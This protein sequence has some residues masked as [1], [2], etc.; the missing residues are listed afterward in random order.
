MTE[1]RDQT[2]REKLMLL[3]LVKKVTFLPGSFD[4][5]FARN[6]QSQN[7]ITEKQADCLEKMYHRYR[8]QIPNHAA[9]CS[10]CMAVQMEADQIRMEI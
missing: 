5:R 9:H 10:I 3:Q 4:K 6:V 1:T 7:C 8:R 2:E